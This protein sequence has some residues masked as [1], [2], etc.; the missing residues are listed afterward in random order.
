MKQVVQHVR[1]RRLEV[2][3]VP[4]PGVRSGG[5]LVRNAAS[6][7]S[8]GTE[9]TI[10]DFAGKSMLGK[11]RDRP[12]LVRQVVD[13]VKKDGI[14]P[15][16]QTVLSRLDQPIALCYSGAGVV[17]AAGRGAEEFS[18][19][20]RVACAG[21]TYA[22]H[23]DVVFVPRNLSV[24]V[25]DGVSLE[26]AAY[27]TVGAIALQGVRVADVR[28]G[29]SVAV[30]GLGLLGQLAVQILRAAGCRV[31][32]VDLDPA[33]V[34]L[35]R[36]LGAEAAVVRTD[37]VHGA[38]AAF[39]GGRGADAVV[40]TAATSSS[41]PVELAGEIARDRAVVSMVGATG[42][43]LPRKPFYD[44]ELQLRL[45]RSYGPGRYDPQYEEKGA[46]Y[47]VG[48]VRWT[49]RRNMEEFLRLVAAGQVTPAAL[50]THRFPVARAEAAYDVIQG[51]TGEPFAGVLLTYP[52]R[53]EPP[54]RRVVL[55]RAA[56]A[57]GALGVGFVGAGNF[58]RAVL[59]PR[60]QKLPEV[61]L[62]GVSTATGMNARAV[63]ERFGFGYAT[64]DTPALLADPAV[65]AVVVATRHA[66][67]AR[68]AAQALRAGKAVFVEKPL[69]LDEAG[70]REVRAAQEE[71]GGVLAVGFN[72]R[73]SPLARVVKDAFTPGVPLA[74]AYR[75]NAGF[76]PRESWIHDP[77]DG[78]GR[79]VGEVCHFIDLCQFLADD[80]PVEAFA[81][82]LGG[83]E[84]GM[85]DTVAITLRFSRG[86]VATISYYATGD[87]SFPKERVEVFAG[88]TLAVLD[89][90]R[91]VVVSRGG[92][93]TR[94]R[95][96]SQD[97]GFDEEVAAFVRAA[98]EG[99][100]LPIPLR[101]LVATTRA[102]F[103]VVT[104][105]QTGAPAPVTADQEG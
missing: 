22:S 14:G 37:D 71:T 91:E 59:L 44:K 67:H 28:L 43:D 49:E 3:E 70:L 81:H 83:A 51:K 97:K 13:R 66:S 78:G 93:R 72:R 77:E 42:M 104:S 95:R 40:I 55:S 38:V 5:I 48:Y 105:L 36:Q 82:A 18:A 19:G 47:P 76:I 90:F 26:D 7:I 68:L 16:V 87:R 12:D 79:I 35:A 92:K 84:G 17:E 88:G 94:T 27:V 73:F 31:I 64:T 20:D 74:I 75:V 29:E 46:D 41:D 52:E 11:A 6:L 9:K 39:T 8:A 30:I 60:F 65:R 23:A 54:V 61:A 99:G 80:E 96:M 57:A 100:A 89:D 1:T 15:T 86:S 50:T 85:H 53:T 32:G 98:R 45:S 21:M 62:A 34:A 56:P 102:T 10:T 25:P 4:E 103:A 69:A 101:S 63:G 2:A 58:A 24:P 33:K